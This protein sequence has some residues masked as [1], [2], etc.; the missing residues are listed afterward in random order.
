MVRD[1]ASTPPPRPPSGRLP[2]ADLEGY[3]ALYQ[4]SVDDPGAY[5][6][7]VAGELEWMSGW[8]ANPVVTGDLAAA[9][10]FT[11]DVDAAAVLVNAYGMTEVCGTLA[12]SR[13][14]D[15]YGARMRSCG[16]LLPEWEAAV[17]EP[18]TGR[19][20]PPGTSGELVTRGRSLFSGYYKNPDQTAASRDADGFFHTGDHCSM[21][22]NGFVSFHGRLR[23]V[24]KVGGEN[25][26]AREVEAFLDSHPSIKMSQIVGISDDRLTEVPVAFVELVP[27]AELHEDDVVAYCRGTI[28][29][30]KVPRHVRFVTEWPMSSTKIQ[31]FRL[32]EQILHELGHDR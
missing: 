4:A 28:A 21:D 8:P 25:V 11:Q 6:A 22:E 30:F 29:S 3:R 16:P 1:P 17:V 23:D 19:R 26:S 9:R 12:Y 2:V 32:R 18:L 27:G 5:W 31:K 15:S 10:R 20:V 7:K 14:D 24:L 13:L